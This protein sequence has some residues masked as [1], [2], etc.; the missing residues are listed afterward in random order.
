MEETISL[1]ELFLILRKRFSMIVSITFAA[2]LISA[3]VSFFFTTPVYES[4]TQILVNQKKQQ[5]V[6]TAG[7]VQTNLQL[8]NTYTGIIKSPAILDGVI[9]NLSLD[10]STGELN[11]KVKVS[12]EKDSQIISVTVQD[13]NP[14]KAKDIANE[15]AN[16]FKQDIPTIMSVDNTTILSQAVEEGSPIKP[17]PSTNIMIAFVVGLIASAGLAF[18]LEYLDNTIKKEEDVEVILGLPILGVIAQM[19]E[20]KLVEKVL[21][22]RSKARE[23]TIGS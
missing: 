15:I 12:S 22:S 9:K 6:M 8:I 1:K 20:K 2:V 3:I 16:V 7:D 10:M 17:R 21:A 14:K 19:E 18:L 4:S 11:G 5:G 23:H 13:S